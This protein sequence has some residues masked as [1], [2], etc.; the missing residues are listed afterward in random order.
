MKFDWNPAHDDVAS[1]K[2]WLAA[3]QPCVQTVD[4]VPA[5]RLFADRG[6]P[7][8]DVTR[9]SIEETAAGI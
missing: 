8:I 2:A 5:R 3:W 1:V 9:R 4:F 7:V 6:W